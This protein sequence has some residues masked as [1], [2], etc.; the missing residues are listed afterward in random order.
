[1]VN[2]LYGGRISRVPILPIFTILP[3]CQVV[4]EGFIY[5][6]IYLSI[7]LCIYV[8]TDAD[9]DAGAWGGGYRGYTCIGIYIVAFP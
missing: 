4:L 6:F 8:D 1:M 9:A 3:V 5:L 7:Y 2:T